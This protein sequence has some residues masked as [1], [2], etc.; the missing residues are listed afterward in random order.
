[1][2]TTWSGE[3]GDYRVRCSIEDLSP[4]VHTIVVEENGRELERYVVTTTPQ[5]RRSPFDVAVQ[6]FSKHCLRIAAA[7]RT[8]E[9]G[10]S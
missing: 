8:A 1:M 9:P 6:L 4:D 7:V 10:D 2:Q 5:N 3:V